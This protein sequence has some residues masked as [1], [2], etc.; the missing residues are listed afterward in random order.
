MLHKV[1]AILLGVLSVVI[2]GCKEDPV[3]ETVEEVS[4]E[5]RDAAN[6]VKD[7]VDDATSGG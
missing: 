4:D 5:I 7:E 1:F 6:E 3:A 2:V